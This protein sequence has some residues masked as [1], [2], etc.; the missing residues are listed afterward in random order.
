MKQY[1]QK[2]QNKVTDLSAT[3]VSGSIL[4][5]LSTQLE[6]VYKT[7]EEAKTQAYIQTAQG[8]Y[9]DRLIY[10]TFGLARNRETRATGY[11]V[12]HA[13]SPIQSP[14]DLRL[15]CAQYTPSTDT[16]VGEDTALKFIT[17]GSEKDSGRVFVLIAPK[18]ASLALEDGNSYINMSG[19]Y[20]Q[21]V[22]VPVVSMTK[23]EAVN[24]PEGAIRIM[25][26]NVPGIT[27][28]INTYSPISTFFSTPTETPLQDRVTSLV[29]L[30]N[31]V[32]EVVNSYNFSGSGLVSVETYDGRTLKGLYQGRLENGGG[33][34]I[35]E[36][37]RD[38]HIEYT[39]AFTKT[40]SLDESA[41][42]S[43]VHTFKRLDDSGRSIVYSLADSWFGTKKSTE[44]QSNKVLDKL[45]NSSISLLVRQVE[46][47][48]DKSIIYDP[49]NVINEQGILIDSARIGGGSNLESDEE[50]RIKLRK[51]LASLGRSTPTA[52][53]AGALTVPGISFAQ[54]LPSYMSPR[55]S[56]TLLVSGDN[57]GINSFQIYELKKVLEEYWKAA[58]IRL[59]VKTPQKVEVTALCRVS[60]SSGYSEFMVEPEIRAVI[61][62]Y[63]DDKLP[64]SIISYSELTA[65]ILDVPGV[66]N[67]WNVYIGRKLGDYRFAVANKTE[68]YNINKNGVTTFSGFKL[69]SVGTAFKTEISKKSL[70]IIDASY[71]TQKN[72]PEENHYKL[73]L[74]GVI[75]S[76]IT[77]NGTEGS[78]F[79]TSHNLRKVANAQDFEKFLADVVYRKLTSYPMVEITRHL[80]E[81][82]D[83]SE[84]MSLPV[85]FEDVTMD[86]MK[87]YKLDTTEVPIIG[88]FRTDKEVLPLIGI[89]FA[90]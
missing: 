83:T 58:G 57:G 21:F 79:S 87:P 10:G 82:L 59:I 22:V 46:S 67:V 85:Y 30:D 55:G 68:K 24:I 80:T 38:V 36:L 78:S 34:V 89:E 16:L 72:A 7:I 42:V 81:P 6:E 44:A 37:V 26:S 45:K 25:S 53:E 27:G 17:S 90:K 28:V 51:Y 84:R 73:L 4:W 35:S 69:S 40:I 18:G 5:S 63:F 31:F 61:R 19:K 54:T 15:W 52:L 60:L 9:L 86:M 39:D 64:G 56:A 12:L 1:Y 20:A 33:N 8:T 47:E 29:N 70:T 62:E 76:S 23:G 88:T 49:D 66:Q 65:A 2:I 3:S 71:I 74:D 41:F 77:W 48:I 43:G 13:N 50:Y 32:L 14:E 11:V 75:D